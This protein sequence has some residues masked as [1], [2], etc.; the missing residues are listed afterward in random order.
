M[1]DNGI[2]LVLSIVGVF[3]VFGLGING[4]FLRGIFKD[5]NDVKVKLA[6][7]SARSEGKEERIKNLESNQKEIFERMNILE[8]E[9]LKWVMQQLMK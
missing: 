4:F 9:I 8:R 2:S 5:L 7:M 6:E 1:S 3:L